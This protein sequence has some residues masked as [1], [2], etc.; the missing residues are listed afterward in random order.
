M[1]Q[2]LHM[3]DD[4]IATQNILWSK[5]I[6]SSTVSQSCLLKGVWILSRYQKN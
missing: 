2:Y 1:F 3:S 6:R 5:Y 4:A